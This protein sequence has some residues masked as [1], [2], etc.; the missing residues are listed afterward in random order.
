[1][2]M[3]LSLEEMTT[4]GDWDSRSKSTKSL[5][6]C[7]SSRILLSYDEKERETEDADAD[8]RPLEWD[9]VVRI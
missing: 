7:Q 3:A 1:M 6:L 5:F 2:N 8:N 4:R 9:V